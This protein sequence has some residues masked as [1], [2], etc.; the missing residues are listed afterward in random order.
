[1]ATINCR[2]C[3]EERT[4]CPSNTRY[5]KPCRLLRQ[6]DYWR[7]RRKNCGDCERQFAPL[8]RSDIYCAAHAGDELRI[9]SVHCVLCRQDGPPVMIGIPVCYICLRSPGRRLELDAALRKGQRLRKE[10]NNA[11]A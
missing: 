4:G 2:D 6:L 7:V 11:T 9:R 1:M 5:C 10:R 8:E 3:G